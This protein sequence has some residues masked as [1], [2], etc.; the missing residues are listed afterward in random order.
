MSAAASAEARGASDRGTPWP[1]RREGAPPPDLVAHLERFPAGRLLAALLWRRGVETVPE[2]RRFL[3]PRLST[4]LRPPWVFPVVTRAGEQLARLVPSSG[5]P[6]II[7]AAGGADAA[8]AAAVFAEW[9]HGVGV[10]TAIGTRPAAELSV[11][12][13]QIR[14]GEVPVPADGTE[15]PCAASGVAFYVCAAARAVRR[16][17]GLSTGIAL[18]RLLDLVAFGT[19]L[20]GRALREENRVLV[21]AGLAQWS[22]GMRP[23]LVALARIA[24]VDR[25][26]AG[27][28]CERLGPRLVAAARTA[29]EAV[30][31]ALLAP[32]EAAAERLAAQLELAVAGRT[33]GPAV[34]PS[35]IVLDAEVD[36]HQLTRETVM[37]LA[38]LEPHGTGN[39]EPVLLARAVVLESVRLMG[40]PAQ[41]MWRLRLRQGSRTWRAIAR[42]SRE[43]APE[44]GAR[45]DIAF[46]PRLGGPAAGS[47][48]EI[49]LHGFRRQ[50][51]EKPSAGA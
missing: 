11:E 22:A 51:R 12:G 2:A 28:V 32:T 36:L 26:S 25:L 31:H 16:G 20:S 33:I 8:I 21:S 17:L 14:I 27:R 19:L 18:R 9:L 41:P 6:V 42:H 47:R 29:P 24:G 15:S 5:A 37:A 44:A 30:V 3:C 1:W 50:T 7:A 40:S 45:Y 43:P 39:P 10:R 35:A 48:L 34:H 13:D 49:Q 23:G 38:R 46:T 4:D